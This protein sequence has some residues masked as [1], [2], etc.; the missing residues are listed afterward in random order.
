MIESM[1]QAIIDSFVQFFAISAPIALAIG[2]AVV[3]IRLFV[4]GVMGRL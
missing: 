2:L 1:S 3:V 4:R